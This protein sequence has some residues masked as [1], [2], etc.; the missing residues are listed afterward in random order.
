MNIF[1]RLLMGSIGGC[2]MTALCWLGASTAHFPLSK[3]NLDEGRQLFEQHC[4]TCHSVDP[5]GRSSYGPNLSNIGVVASQ[6]IPNQSSQHYILESIVNPGAYRV[7]GTT[8]AM[9]ADIAEDLE[10]A[11][12]VSLVGYLMTRGAT[13]DH[14]ELTQLVHHVKIAP[15][16]NS[17]NVDFP[18]VDAGRALYF[19]KGG[20]HKCHSLQELPGAS[21]KA[22]NLLTAGNHS[23]QYLWESIC[24]PS[25]LVVPAYRQTQIILDSGQIVTGRLV[26]DSKDYVELL[27]DSADGLKLDKIKRDEIELSTEGQPSIHQQHQSAMPNDLAKSLTPTEIGQLIAFL[28]TLR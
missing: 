26:T 11:Q 19:G 9:P 2:L 6:R 5:N 8:S 27:V 28:K 20:C 7:P 13:P 3:I 25:R 24:E 23:Q 21:L 1:I 15:Q 16:E 10:P 4:A 14:A 17:G 12:V 18:T 22:P